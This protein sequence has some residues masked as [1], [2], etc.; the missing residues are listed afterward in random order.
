MNEIVKAE[1]YNELIEDCRN[2]I[3]EHSFTAR[4]AMVECYHKIGERIIQDLPKLTHQ[5]KTVDI[6][7]QHVGVSLGKSKTSMYYAYQ[8]ATKF[9]DLNKL[10]EGKNTTWRDIVHKHLPSPMENKAILPLPKGK[11][12]VI[13]AD[14][15]WQFD[16]AGLE[17]SAE[18]HYPTLETDEICRIPVQNITTEQSVLFLWATNA[19]LEDALRVMRGWGFKYKSNM[20][21]IKDKGPS[22]GWFTVSRHELLLIGT[23]EDNVHPQKKFCSWFKGDVTKHSKKPNTVYEMIEDMY[24]GD[25]LEMF[26]RQNRKG[27]LA[28][29]NEISKD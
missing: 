28:Y 4:W 13:L 25:Y 17:E 22:I 12:R 26:A 9:P 21:W 23:K 14:P 10:P 8:F 5:Y 2:I 19:M 3:V 24:N 6:S 18:S 20:V 7:L 29:G 16:N 27:W 1:W 11:F 15:P